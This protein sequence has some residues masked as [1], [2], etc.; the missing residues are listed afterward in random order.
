MTNGKAVIPG[1]TRDPSVL[2]QPRYE[3]ASALSCVGGDMS[4][5][6]QDQAQHAIHVID[7]HLKLYI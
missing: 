7:I 6:S 5:K 2:R 3:L 1:L 4:F